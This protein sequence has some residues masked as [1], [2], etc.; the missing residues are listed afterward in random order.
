MSN[1]AKT[2][3]CFTEITDIQ[4]LIGMTLRDV[5]EVFEQLSKQYGDCAVLSNMAFDGNFPYVE[6]EVPLD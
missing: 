2:Y 5:K 6:V 1:F 3:D 4:P